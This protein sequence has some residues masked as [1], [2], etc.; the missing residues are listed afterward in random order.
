[1]N[2][3]QHTMNN[4]S[5]IKRDG[6]RS[7]FIVHRSFNR[8]STLLFSLVIM[9]TI[10]IVSVAIG[11][12]VYIEINLVKANNETIVATYAAESALEQGAY[13]VRNSNDTIGALSASK[14]FALNS[15]SYTRL[16]TSTEGSLVLRPLLKGLTRGFDFYDPDNAS[17]DYSGKRESVKI[18]ID[19]C[20]GSE[21]IEIGYQSVNTVTWAL[22]NYQKVRYNCGASASPVTIYNDDIQADL[23][24]RLYIRYVQGNPSSLSRVMVTGCT[25]NGGAGTCSL[26]G[27]VDITA[28]GSYRKA[29]RFMDLTMPR[30]SPITGIF[31]YGLFSECSIIKD[32]TNPSPGC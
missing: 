16:A 2:N 10:L 4:S 17:S 8:G 28:T 11:Q 24:Y 1:M 5:R 22:G 23:A 9:A 13:R 31:D 6:N 3:E 21:W 18:T 30:I 15:A 19:S 12:I 14:T 27:R 7:S 26:P 32:P 29:T 20:D 25:G